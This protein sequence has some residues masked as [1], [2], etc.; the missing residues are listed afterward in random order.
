M[1]LLFKSS[2]GD[3]NIKGYNLYPLDSDPS[4]VVWL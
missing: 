2:N 1:P 4:L 3:T